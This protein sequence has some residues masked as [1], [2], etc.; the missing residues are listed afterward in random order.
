MNNAV[1]LDAKGYEKIA[2]EAPKIQVLTISI[3][4]DKFKINGSVARKL[5]RDLESKGLVKRVGDH[6]NSF[7]LYTGTQ[8]GQKA[9]EPVKGEKAEGAPA[10]GG[11]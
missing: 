11:K 10:T 8:Y 5:L 3:V 1:F 9:P 7:N 4:C 6:H 2:K